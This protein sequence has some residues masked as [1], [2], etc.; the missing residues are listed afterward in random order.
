MRPTSKV[1]IVQGAYGE[2]YEL[3]WLRALNEIG[4]ETV[5]FNAHAATLPWIVGRVERRLLW[6]PGIYGLRRGVVKRVIDFKPD[7]TLLYQGHYFDRAF[8]QRLRGLTFVAGYH[9]DDP[10][11][12]RR[13]MLRYR[14]LARAV[15]AYNGFHVYRPVNVSDVESQG[16]RNVAVLMPYYLPWCDFPRNDVVSSRNW[17]CDVVFAGHAEH[18]DRSACISAVVRAGR[19]VRIYGEGKYWRRVLPRDVL[20]SLPPINPIFGDGYR[21]AL[22]A[23]KIAACFFS[24][25]NRDV[26]TRRAFEIPAC[27]TL[28]LS[29]RT[30]AMCELFREGV[31][32]DYF[33]S[34]E[35]FAS[36]VDYYL[37]RPA[38]RDRV[39]AAGRRRLMV[40]GHDIHSRMR[41]WL[42]D[43]DR[44][45]GVFD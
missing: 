38:I 17:Q 22:S 28:L 12:P 40:S 21:Y 29:E 39:A 45:R 24:K 11:G 2:T 27:G 5:M 16:Q 8:V 20:Q 7:V 15:S 4:V 18:D 30:D 14:H 35:E 3:A 10:F 1:L 42:S 25:V 32:A 23:A 9:N 44:W 31:E 13:R 34:S 43:I 36:K 6:G 37:G 19:S 41:Q 33:S 26:Y